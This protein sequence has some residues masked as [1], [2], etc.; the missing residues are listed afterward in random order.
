M[1]NKFSYQIFSDQRNTNLCILHKR[2]AMEQITFQT[3]LPKTT[4]ICTVTWLQ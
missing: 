4:V 1:K 3:F 2:I